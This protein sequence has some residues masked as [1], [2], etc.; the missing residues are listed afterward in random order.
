MRA[1]WMEYPTVTKLNLSVTHA[2]SDKISGFIQADNLTGNLAAERDNTLAQ[3]GL[4]T[5]VGFRFTH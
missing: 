1:Y 2:F 4:W 5:T 3:H